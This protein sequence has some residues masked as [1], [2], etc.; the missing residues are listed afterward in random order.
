MY[1]AASIDHPDKITVFR[2]S[3]ARDMW[4]HHLNDDDPPIFPDRV[5]L[6][7][8]Q[9]RKLVGDFDES[10]LDSDVLFV[11]SGIAFI[12]NLLDMVF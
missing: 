12:D 1:Y 9:V 10:Y 4:V 6:S 7:Y 3:D 5:P 2:D 8:D 11:N